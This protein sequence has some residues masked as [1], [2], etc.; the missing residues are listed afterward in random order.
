MAQAQVTGLQEAL[1][2]VS[3]PAPLPATICLPAV[4][5]CRRLCALLPE[6]VR[7]AENQPWPASPCLP[8]PAE[9]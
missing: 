1:R 8:C 6:A 3:Q 9:N 5:A 2:R 7:N 4:E